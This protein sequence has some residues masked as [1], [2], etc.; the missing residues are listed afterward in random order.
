MD[1][2]SVEEK[3]SQ[4]QTHSGGGDDE[5]SAPTSYTELFMSVF[6]SY[7][8][9]GMTYEQFW[10][11]PAWLAKAYRDAYEIKKRNEE[12][13][14]WRQGAYFYDALRR[15]AP[16]MRAAFGK[17]RVKAEKYPDLPWPLTEKE[18]IEREEA[19]KRQR[20]ER[21]MAMLNK[22]S[23]DTLKKQQEETDE[24]KVVSDNG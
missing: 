6:P 5:N 8:V 7:M 10:H 11:G 24:A 19:E 15:V 18:A 20:F 3:P 1:G 13:S 17:G 22:E 4:D 23:E 12:W 9:M 14:R 16:V 21:F 2:N